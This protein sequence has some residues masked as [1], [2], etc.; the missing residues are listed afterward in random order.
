MEKIMCKYYR[1]DERDC[2]LTGEDCSGGDKCPLMSYLGR[3]KKEC[4]EIEE[5]LF[6]GEMSHTD[7]ENWFMDF[8]TRIGVMTEITEKDKPVEEDIESRTKVLREIK[9]LEEEEHYKK[10]CKK[11]ELGLPHALPQGYVV[12]YGNIKGN[13]CKICN[14][15]FVE[16][17]I[18]ADKGADSLC[19][20]HACQKGII[21]MDTWQYERMK[22]EYGI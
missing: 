20:V 4:A 19:Q 15:I 10:E 22:K 13:M 7:L 8:C 9:Q 14:R 12:G 21:K 1:E 2:A 6:R 5:L 3:Q 11:T 17:E 16:G 18:Y